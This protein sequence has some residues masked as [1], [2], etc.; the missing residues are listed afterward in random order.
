M[1]MRSWAV[2]IL[3]VALSGGCGMGVEEAPLP[4]VMASQSALQGAPAPA[5]STPETSVN[6]LGSTSKQSS[7]VGLPQDPIPWRPPGQQ[8]RPFG[9]P[10][11]IPQ[12][13]GVG[14]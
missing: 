10:S 2:G 12:T 1:S 14:R 8:G 5:A 6:S 4:G 9:P 7:V 11:S 13:G 3:A